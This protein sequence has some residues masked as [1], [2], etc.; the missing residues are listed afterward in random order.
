MSQIDKQSTASTLIKGYE[1]WRY[2]VDEAFRS[3]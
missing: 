2:V 1:I 3:D